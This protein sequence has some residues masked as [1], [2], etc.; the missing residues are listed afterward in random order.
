MDPRGTPEGAVIAE[1]ERNSPAAT[2]GLR[3]GDVVT[4]LNGHPVRSASELRARLGVVPAGETV[5]LKIQRGKESQ[6]VKA[7]VAEIDGSRTAGGATLPQLGGASLVDVERGKNR[8]VLVN[9]VEA[10]SPA[11]E[12][13]IR[14]G[15]LIIGVNQRRVSTVPELGKA[16]RGSGR[17]A[18]NV[19]RGDFLLTIQLR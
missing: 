11:F 17:L 9:G 14:A 7:R 2:A 3:K 19:V 6:L 8:A 5:E 15:D 16:L 13:G 4:A 18:L 1:V 12:H 10:G